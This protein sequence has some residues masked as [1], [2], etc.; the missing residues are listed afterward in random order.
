MCN[1]RQRYRFR[2][3]NAKSVP[4]PAITAVFQ[5]NVVPTM[6][7]FRRLPRYYRRPHPHAV[8]YFLVKLRLKYCL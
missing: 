8:L 6:A 5:A 3:I 7:V 1:H 4:V 2:G